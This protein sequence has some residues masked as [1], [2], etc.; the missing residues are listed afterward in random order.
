MRNLNGA[1]RVTE[2]LIL[3]RDKFMDN[4][5]ELRYL[6]TSDAVTDC[7]SY[8]S[9]L[10]FQ[11]D[12]ARKKR[13][14]VSALKKS[15]LYRTFPVQSRLQDK[16]IAYSKIAV[17]KYVEKN[18]RAD[19]IIF[20][21]IYTAYHF[22]N[23]FPAPEEKTVLIT[24]TDTDPLEQL[25]INRPELKR[26]QY[27]K[28]LRDILRVVFTNVDTV[29]TICH[30]S[31][32]YLREN[33]PIDPVCIHNGIEDCHVISKHD[34]DKIK[35]VILGSVIYRKGHDLLIDAIS[36]MS[37]ANRE[38]MELHI[39]GE[40]NEFQEIKKTIECRNLSDVCIMHGMMTDVKPILPMMDVM[41]LPS[42]ADTVP[43]SIIE[44]MRAGL[45]VIA[46]G[47]GEI[48][49]MIDG[50]GVIIGAN[51]EDIKGALEKTISG[52]YDIFALGKNARERF[53]KLFAL[54]EMIM[55][56]SEV[57]NETCK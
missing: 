40:G 4:G 22:F 31:Q 25:F 47:V 38:K 39:I 42:R 55:R 50:C 17:D 28:K 10:G 6:I 51:V 8:V 3:G 46:T 53:L 19:C 36:A 27:E 30:S 32:N 49:Y 48:P 20:Q 26:K 24:H 13:K 45:P 7:S 44:G 5:I 33:Y 41:I 52:Q 35:F 1:N 29:V 54:D 16:T 12:T 11:T 15:P 21:D 2:K 57:I 34:N 23:A 18:E 56:Y 37:K 9:K 14:L 43:I